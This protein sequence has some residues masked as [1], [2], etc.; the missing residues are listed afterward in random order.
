MQ[1]VQDIYTVW[2]V[3]GHFTIR[4]TLIMKLTNILHC[5]WSYMTNRISDTKIIQIPATMSYF[6]L[7][8]NSIRLT[9]R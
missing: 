8:K 2:T 4:F 1:E 3:L 7:G 9:K 5:L 6:F